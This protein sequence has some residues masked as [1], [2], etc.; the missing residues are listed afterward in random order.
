MNEN[1]KPGGALR[2]LTSII[3]FGTATSKPLCENLNKKESRSITVDDE[4]MVASFE[5]SPL[6]KL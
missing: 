6:R 2:R 4:V 5:M 3:N 1:K